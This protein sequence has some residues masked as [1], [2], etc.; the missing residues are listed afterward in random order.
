[1]LNAPWSTCNQK[2]KVGIV[3]PDMS[4]HNARACYITESPPVALT[5]DYGGPV[6]AYADGVFDKR[7]NR[8]IT[9]REGP[10]SQLLYQLN[11]RMAALFKVESL[12]LDIHAAEED[13]TR[14]EATIR[15]KDVL[16][17]QSSESTPKALPPPIVLSNSIHVTTTVK[18]SDSM[19]KL[20]TAKMENKRACF[21]EPATT[22]IKDLDSTKKLAMAKLENRRACF[23]D[24]VTATDWLDSHPFPGRLSPTR[25][26][27]KIDTVEDLSSNEG[28]DLGD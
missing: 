22:T 6:V 13:N 19:K 14:W 10:L 3:S 24:P 16:A 1:M 18:N 26:E 25:L 12:M 5:P 23:N 9:V 28:I 4:I 2:F 20:T 17:R 15:H 7:L 11:S 27:W 8:Y 21:N